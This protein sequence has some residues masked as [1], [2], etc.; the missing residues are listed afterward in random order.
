MILGQFGPCSGTHR[1]LV[2]EWCQESRSSIDRQEDR[3][4][5]E[6]VSN[7]IERVLRS[8]SYDKLVNDVRSDRAEHA[9]PVVQLNQVG[10]RVALTRRG[11]P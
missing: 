10:F 9:H 3:E 2:C 6:S 11:Q 7:L 4:D 8:G 5:T 1:T